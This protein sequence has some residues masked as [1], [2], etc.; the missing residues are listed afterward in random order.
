MTTTDFLF[1]GGHIF[2]NRNY[3]AG[4]MSQSIPM[5]KQMGKNVSIDY[6][7]VDIAGATRDL[8]SIGFTL[9]E[10]NRVDKM[11]DVNSSVVDN[12]ISDMLRDFFEEDISIVRGT[13]VILTLMQYAIDNQVAETDGGF[14]GSSERS[15]GHYF[16]YQLTFYSK[17]KASF[18]FLVL[19]LCAFKEASSV[20]GIPTSFRTGVA[21]SAQ[22]LEVK[23]K[24][25]N[26]LYEYGR[27][28]GG[29]AMASPSGQ[30]RFT[31]GTDGN[32]TVDGRWESNSA[33][34]GVAP[35]YLA[36]QED[37]NLCVYG[38]DGPIWASGSQPGR[39]SQG[40]YRLEMQDDGNLVVYDKS[41]TS[42][43]AIGI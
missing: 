34:K 9:R 38:T 20:F 5:L 24:E 1:E 12:S 8:S 32:V 3:P 39:F 37:A 11:S 10:T 36:M 15:E 16:S 17:R 33:G 23:K 25:P 28:Q 13:D 27:L 42:L 29:D 41:N 21:Y 14:F 30:H 19:S 31:M 40:P 7:T 43:W 22:V 4:V 6:A 26:V 35:Y 2:N 18:C